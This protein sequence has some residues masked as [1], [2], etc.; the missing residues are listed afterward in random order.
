MLIVQHF[1]FQFRDL[2]FE[3]FKYVNSSALAEQ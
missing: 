1:S 3:L 2:A